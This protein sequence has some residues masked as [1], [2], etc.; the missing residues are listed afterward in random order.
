MVIPLLAER[1]LQWAYRLAA[2]SMAAASCG[3]AAVSVSPSGS[4]TVV[5]AGR[6]RMS[7]PQVHRS[8][9]R[10]DRRRPLGRSD[11]GQCV[12][13]VRRRA[14][15]VAAWQGPGQ[16]RSARHGPPRHR[17]TGRDPSANQTR[18]RSACPR[19]SAWT[20]TGF[21]PA[22]PR[23]RSRDRQPAANR[24]RGPGRLPLLLADVGRRFPLPG[25]AGTPV[26]PRR[27]LRIIVARI[28]GVVQRRPGGH[29]R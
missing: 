4:V 5:R 16:R 13:D 28:A 27:S 1:I 12:V 3:L 7:C 14:L 10:S 25:L 21:V 20:A 23:V 9:F 2:A 6:G 8:H 24:N 19:S 15:V 17:C 22:C 29:Q 26:D 11:S 18:E